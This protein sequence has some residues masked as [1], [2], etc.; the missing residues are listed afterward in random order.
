MMCVHV[1][2]C[3]AP[4]TDVLFHKLLIYVDF[5]PLLVDDADTHG[6]IL[7]LDYLYKQGVNTYTVREHNIQ[8]ESTRRDQPRYSH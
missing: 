1:S 5:E 6:P 4:L 7:L 3:A 2:M 8:S